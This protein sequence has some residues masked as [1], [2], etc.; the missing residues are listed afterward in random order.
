MLTAPLFATLKYIYYSDSYTQCE[1][2]TE[3]VK[4][5]FFT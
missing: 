2:N 5:I 1:Q 4:V 3:Q